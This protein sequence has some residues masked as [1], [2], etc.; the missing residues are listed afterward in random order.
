[1]VFGIITTSPLGS[2][3]LQQA[4]ALA[5]IYLD[6]AWN[7]VDPNVSLVL[8]HD[9]EVSLSQAKK[10]IKRT[11]DSTVTD[12]IVTAYE[13]LGNLLDKLGYNSEAKASY[14]KAM[15]LG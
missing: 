11:E 10:S 3:P 2:L 9:T 1:M 6:N 4:L 8:C 14:K 7:A 13:S 15:R 5:K 12:R